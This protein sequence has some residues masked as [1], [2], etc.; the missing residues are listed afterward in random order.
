M[1]I[2]EDK[3]LSCHLHH[4][5]AHYRDADSKAHN[6]SR[7]L[8]ARNSAV[9]NWPMMMI[10][11]YNNVRQKALLWA[12]DRIEAPKNNSRKIGSRDRRT[13]SSSLNGYAVRDSLRWTTIGRKRTI[14][15]GEIHRLKYR[16]EVVKEVTNQTGTIGDNNAIVR[17]LVGTVGTVAAARTDLFTAGNG[18]RTVNT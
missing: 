6:R 18:L 7:Y 17:N 5:P 4:K 11:R 15:F 16:I 1:E 14:I 9:S 3:N 12:H 2:H 13:T 10:L 8:T